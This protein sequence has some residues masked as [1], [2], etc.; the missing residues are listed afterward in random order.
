MSP[1]GRLVRVV[2]VGSPAEEERAWSA[3]GRILM[4]VL[5]KHPDLVPLAQ[6]GPGL[7]DDAPGQHRSCQAQSGSTSRGRYAARLDRAGAPV[8]S[9]VNPAGPIGDGAS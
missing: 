6:T 7:I 1:S 2:A 5:Q 3:L 4:M 9:P 8:E